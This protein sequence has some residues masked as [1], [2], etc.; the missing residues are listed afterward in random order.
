[1]SALE[2]GCISTRRTTELTL[3]TFDTLN[4]VIVASHGP[5]LSCPPVP[6]AVAAMPLELGYASA[7]SSRGEYP[8]FFRSFLAR[9]KKFC[10][11]IQSRHYTELFTTLRSETCR[12]GWRNVRLTSDCPGDSRVCIFREMQ[13]PTTN[14]AGSY[15][16][17]NSAFSSSLV[18]AM[19]PTDKSIS[20]T[21]RQAI[22]S[23]MKNILSPSSLPHEA[24]KRVSANAHA[25]ACVEEFW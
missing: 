5:V 2:P 9:L 10:I 20:T 25:R 4:L 15:R 14:T 24:E 3:F 11:W 7:Q 13:L 17:E 23:N 6:R 22:Y 8:S 12:S 18:R 19:I 1:M 21:K 16:L